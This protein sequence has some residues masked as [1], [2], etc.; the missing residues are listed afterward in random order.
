MHIH[1]YLNFLSWYDTFL[2]FHYIF[3][4]NSVFTLCMYACMHV[5]MY[6]C[7]HVCVYVCMYMRIKKYIIV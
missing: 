2:Y 4:S 7:M 1:K 6:A 5:C 3:N